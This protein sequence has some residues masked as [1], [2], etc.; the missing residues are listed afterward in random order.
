LQVSGIEINIQ[1]AALDK[2][3]RQILNLEMQRLER[4][5][6]KK[7]SWSKKIA[8]SPANAPTLHCCAA[9]GSVPYNDEIQLIKFPQK[10]FT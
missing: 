3:E 6:R 1:I 10:N 5:V 9:R 8:A 7:W 4:S 2:L